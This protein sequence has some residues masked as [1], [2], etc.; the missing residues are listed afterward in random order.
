LSRFERVLVPEMN[1]GQLA[2][3]L[4]GHYLKDVVSYPKVQGKPFFRGEILAKI[5]ALMESKPHV[6]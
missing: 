6:H 4:R 1:L 5:E 2:F 3:L